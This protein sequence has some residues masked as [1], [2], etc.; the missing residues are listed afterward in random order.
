MDEL[1]PLVYDD[2]PQQVHAVARRSLYAHVIKLAHDGRV[3][4]KD[5]TWKLCS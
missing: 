3:T 2:V 1:L 4:E 5:G